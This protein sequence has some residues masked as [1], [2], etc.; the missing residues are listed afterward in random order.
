MRNRLR[1]PVLALALFAALAPARALAQDPAPFRWR[2]LYVGEAPEETGGKRVSLDLTL[3]DD[4]FA[5]GRLSFGSRGEYLSGAGSYDERTAIFELEL[6]DS[7][8][9]AAPSVE[10][11]SAYYASLDSRDAAREAGVD[12]GEA[13][14]AALLTGEL[15]VDRA[16]YR[17][18]LTFELLPASGRG[19]AGERLPEPPAPTPELRGSLRRV[20]QWAFTRVSEG[21]ID[22]GYAV[23]RFVA[24]PASLDDELNGAAEKTL[25]QWLAE[26][27]ALIASGNG[28]GWAWTHSQT[29]DVAGTAGAFRSYLLNFRYYTGG[30]HPNSHAESV[31]ARIEGEGYALLSLGTLFEEGAPWRARL[32]ELVLASL[33]EQEAQWVVDGTIT[34]LGEDDLQT[35]TLSTAGLTF[36][37]D[38]YAVGPYVQGPFSVTLGFRE[39]LP[40]AAEGG[41]IV[42]F[43]AERYR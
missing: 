11:E 5:F 20:A 38:P 2:A 32:S 33:S 13:E 41:A 37:F 40:L 23:P 4:G 43:A 10:A 19:D 22:L 15:T 25:K 21:R 39:L 27:R 35:F 12:E 18:A 36:H 3:G 6:H 9:F 26:G 28:V 8:R 14:A 29:V 17:G 24:G 16:N 31:L 7:T 30:A 34:E 42:A 1:F